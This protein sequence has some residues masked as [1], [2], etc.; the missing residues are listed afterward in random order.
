M[1]SLLH[2]ALFVLAC[3]ISVGILGSPL[4]TCCLFR[5]WYPQWWPLLVLP[6]LHS[7]SMLLAMVRGGAEMQSRVRPSNRMTTPFL[8]IAAGSA[9]KLSACRWWA[10]A[11]IP[12]FERHWVLCFSQH[13]WPPADT[14]MLMLS[15]V[16]VVKA[17]RSSAVFGYSP[18]VLVPTTVHN[19]MG[20]RSTGSLLI[21]LLHPM[22]LFPAPSGSPADWYWD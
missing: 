20:A 11:A 3:L 5:L 9:S 16:A 17:P 12:S 4:A 21:L 2:L 13:V 22:F 14:C 6:L 1:R 7:C 10:L 18:V 19:A 15:G 8:W